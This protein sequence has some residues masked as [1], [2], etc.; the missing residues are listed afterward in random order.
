MRL[1]LRTSPE[2]GLSLQGPN[3]AGMPARLPGH[4]GH[5]RLRRPGPLSQRHLLLRRIWDLNLK[6]LLEPKELVS[7][8]LCPRAAR[9][10]L[11]G[12]KLAT[13][14]WGPG[15]TWCPASQD[16]RL[17]SGSCSLSRCCGPKAAGRR[18]GLSPTGPQ[19]AWPGTSP[20]RT[21]P[22]SAGGPQLT[23]VLG[24]NPASSQVHWK[25]PEASD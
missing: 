3:M 5:M 13:G 11:T 2:G 12:L 1:R 19:G 9:V 15:F 6:V 7:R 24:C 4:I 14:P 25:E 22:S 10:T 18:W 8:E 21:L 20:G 16:L 17:D 23:S